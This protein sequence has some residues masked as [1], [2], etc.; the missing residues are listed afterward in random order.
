MELIDEDMI[1]NGEIIPKDT[2]SDVIHNGFIDKRDLRSMPYA[3]REC[4]VT[5]MNAVCIDLAGSCCKKVPYT[6]MHSIEEP[7][8]VKG[9]AFEYDC[10]PKH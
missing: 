1:N 4:I 9:T 6:I 10:Y 5:T 7:L 8:T 2:I 3:A